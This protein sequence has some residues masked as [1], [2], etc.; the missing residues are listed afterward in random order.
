MFILIFIFFLSNKARMDRY[1]HEL[2]GEDT[3]DTDDTPVFGCFS[4]YTMQYRKQYY[5]WSKIAPT[6]L[7]STPTM[8]PNSCAVP[9]STP[10]TTTAATDSM[11]SSLQLENLSAK[12]QRTLSTIINPPNLNVEEKLGDA[13]SKSQKTCLPN[14]G[15]NAD[16]QIVNKVLTTP[17][18]RRIEVRIF[19]QFYNIEIA[20]IKSNILYYFS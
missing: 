4:S 16:Q 17:Q 14:V 5:S 7:T 6:S 3:D 19:M 12:Q 15:I 20:K 8:T 2:A 1:N 13:M 9:I 10:T 18:L 11:P